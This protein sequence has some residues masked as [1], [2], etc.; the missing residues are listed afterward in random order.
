MFRPIYE[1]DAGG[2]K[3][4]EYTVYMHIFP[5][6]K[7][8]IGLTKNCESRFRNGHGYDGSPLMKNAIQ[9]YGWSNIVHEIIADHLT[10]QQAKEIEIEHIENYHTTDS[11]FG[12]NITLGGE[13]GSGRVMT[14]EQKAIIGERMSLANKG[15]KMSEEQKALISSKL[16]GRPKNYSEQG[17]QR[18]IESNR[19]RVYSKDTRRKMSINTKKAM[20][21]KNIGERLR[22]K[23]KD[24]ERRKAIIRL[25][26]YNRYGYISEKHD[27]R[28]DI[29]AYEDVSHYEEFDFLKDTQ[30]NYLRSI[31]NDSLFD[32]GVVL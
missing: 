21:D 27:I 18:I 4:I 3:Y 2:D 32:L 22:E 28:K 16:I 6:G 25:T 17:R 10:R 31:K 5:N 9:K 26:Y 23:W 12:Y 15:K 19:N 7:R 30:G 11:S 13:G 24:K 1:P 20:E 14:S 29:E 8:Y